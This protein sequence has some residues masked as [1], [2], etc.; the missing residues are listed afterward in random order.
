MVQRVTEAN[1]RTAA[2]EKWSQGEEINGCSNGEEKS[3]IEVTRGT[4]IVW[5]EDKGR[6]FIASKALQAG[7]TFLSE[8]P[9]A[10]ILHKSLRRQR[11]HFCFQRLPLDPLPCFG[12]YS[13]LYCGEICR[14]SALSGDSHSLFSQNQKK[15]EDRRVKL[16]DRWDRRMSAH[17]IKE[18]AQEFE[19]NFEEELQ[20]RGGKKCLANG[21]GRKRSVSNRSKCL[22]EIRERWG[23][24][25]HECGGLS[26]AVVLPERAAMAARFLL[27]QILEETME[28]EAEEGKEKDEEVEEEKVKEQENEKV[29]KSG[30]ENWK[31]KE[32]RPRIVASVLQEHMELIP[33]EE[34]LELISLA[35][36][37]S[38]CLK[39]AMIQQFE[40]F[41][42]RKGGKGGE[43]ERR[44][45]NGK[46]NWGKT[47]LMVYKRD[48]AVVGE[49]D[50]TGVH[51]L[52]EVKREILKKITGW[53][54]F[55]TFSVLRNNSIAV[56]E[57]PFSE[58]IGNHIRVTDGA[59]KRRPMEAFLAMESHKEESIGIALYSTASL[60]NHS[61]SPNSFASFKNRTIFVRT[62]QDVSP[63]I[64]LEISYGPEKGEA[65][66]AERRKKL[67]ENWGFY[68][69]CFSCENIRERDLSL[70]GYRCQSSN[71]LGVVLGPNTIEEDLE[72]FSEE[73]TDHF[74]GKL[75]LTNDTA[76]I[77]NSEKKR[78]RKKEREKGEDKG[79][80][81]NDEDKC[82]QHKGKKDEG[83]TDERHPCSIFNKEESVPISELESIDKNKLINSNKSSNTVVSVKKKAIVGKCSSC[84]KEI[85]LKR[86]ILEEEE[87]TFQLNESLKV[88]LNGSSKTGYQKGKK[89]EEGLQMGEIAE[90]QSVY[91]LRSSLTRIATILHTFN[92][93]LAQW[94]D[95]V[96][97][98]LCGIGSYDM[99][100]T[101]LRTSIQILQC[102]YPLESVIFAYERAKLASVLLAAGRQ[103]EAQMEKIAANKLLTNHYGCLWFR[104]KYRRQFVL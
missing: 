83:Y 74:F 50:Q 5:T 69:K 81:G 23:E 104:S 16:E 94:N 59:E 98:A 49:E 45:G 70:W 48:K 6:G 57:P 91:L 96:A 99:A 60:L 52:E 11:C 18:T 97:E 65:T 19:N 53:R 36:V 10:A 41:D 55:W 22:E 63:G 39:L 35:M 38:S 27:R 21:S 12:C 58:D 51:F 3:S 71:C 85:N 101:Y 75:E 88:V 17:G 77:G 28:E 72:Y 56:K 100:T 37:V 67:F 86:F 31:E 26:W 13:S 32:K 24:H 89:R 54:L 25:R 95:K 82:N 7:E 47:N 73:K 4:K 103:R 2:L 64:A 46:G 102:H 20:K 8:M 1:T 34:K 14:K 29:T 30:M 42:L 9:Y 76:E 90:N 40:F 43:C 44:D 84:Q 15:G 92:R 66:S 87:A 80:K 62:V 78:E 93:T 61:C 33:D 79:Q 68:C